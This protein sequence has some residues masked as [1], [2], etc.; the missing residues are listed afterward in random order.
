MKSDVVLFNGSLCNASI[1]QTITLHTKK[2]RTLGRRVVARCL[3]KAQY[4]SVPL[5][6][7]ELAPSPSGSNRWPQ[8]V[9]AFL[10]LSAVAAVSAHRTAPAPTNSK[11]PT[12]TLVNKG[13]L[14]QKD[15]TTID[16][17]GC[18]DGKLGPVLGGVDLVRDT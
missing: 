4:E 12:S 17:V 14:Q 5:G 9:L 8:V 13:A 11:A 2:S 16:Y 18:I 7:G 3:M 6:E 10:A 15:S 1:Y